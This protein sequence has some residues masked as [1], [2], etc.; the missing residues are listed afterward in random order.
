M[1]KSLYEIQDELRQIIDT[2]EENGGEIDEFTGE[3]LEIKQE[4][5]ES[6]IESYCNAI[7]ILKSEAECCKN[8]KQRINNLQN[9]KKN[10]IEKLRDR[11]LDA[12]LVW[13]TTG[14]TGNKVLNLPT[15]KLFTKFTPTFL[16][17][18]DRIATLST[19]FKSYILEL[20]RN[21][22]LVTGQ[23]IDLKGMMAAIN[24][25][26][27]T[28]KGENYPPFTVNDLNY[29]EY[30]FT[31]KYSLAQMFDGSHDFLFDIIN[32]PN[33]EVSTEANEKDAKQSIITATELGIEPTCTIGAVVDK[34]SLTIK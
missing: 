17:N 27:R 3:A 32:S 1:S 12:V 20:K 30:G 9:T 23:D 29:I 16:P 28:E 7:T 21:G 4:E 10:I 5:F 25:L 6:K 11:I 31:G 22:I 18:E 19:Y 26:I 13:G 24:A 2:I 15:R 8:E 14:K 34:P 33:V